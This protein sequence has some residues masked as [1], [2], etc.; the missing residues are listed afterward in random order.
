MVRGLVEQEHVGLLEENAAKCHATA[1]S[2]RERGDVGVA[3]WEAKR[4][5]GDLDLAIQ[6][7]GSGGVDTILELRLLVD[8]RVHLVIRRDVPE[9]RRDLFEAP[10]EISR[11]G[12]GDFHVAANVEIRVELRLLREVSD[13]GALGRPCLTEEVRV[14]PRHDPEQRALARAVRADDADLGSRVERQV[15]V[16]ED[17]PLRRD[18]LREAVHVIDELRSGHRSRSR[19]VGA[20][21]AR[22]RI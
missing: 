14:Q 6:I 3:R 12:D 9:L 5:H 21:C 1:L 4:V 7:P 13:P 19:G 16:L 20:P 17:L 15:D 2:T 18:D 8:Q 11:V 10:Q 22:R